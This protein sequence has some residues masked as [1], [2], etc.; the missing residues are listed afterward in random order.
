VL[1]GRYYYY[2]SDNIAIVK[3][4]NIVNR[5][6]YFRLRLEQS[7]DNKHGRKSKRK[8]RRAIHERTDDGIVGSRDAT[9]NGGRSQ[10][11]YAFHAIPAATKV[12][13]LAG[14]AAAEPERGDERHAPPAPIAKLGGVEWRTLDSAA[15]DAADRAV[16]GRPPP[17]ATAGHYE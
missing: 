9:A 2:Y 10:P 1:S 16:D 15:D 12:C 17:A 3:T 11:P 8:L 7:K 4:I 14:A 5:Q 6:L 13:R